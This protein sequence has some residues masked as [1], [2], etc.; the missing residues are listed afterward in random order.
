MSVVVGYQ[1][2]ASPNHSPQVLITLHTRA[3][4]ANIPSMVFIPGIRS[5][6]LHEL[7]ITSPAH[8][9]TH[10]LSS[11]SDL[12]CGTSVIHLLVVWRRGLP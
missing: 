4:I 9:R 11:F 1:T 5:S 3:S 10:R 2:I 8:Q 7:S 6:T 12:V